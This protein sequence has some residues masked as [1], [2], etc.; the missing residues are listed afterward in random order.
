MPNTAR[1]SWDVEIRERPHRVSALGGLAAP[2]REVVPERAAV[3]FADASTADLVAAAARLSRASVLYANLMHQV[4]VLETRGRGEEE[5]LAA[6]SRVATS[7]L[8]RTEVSTGTEAV[9]TPVEVRGRQCGCLVLFPTGEV[10][11]TQV[12]ML[13]RAAAAV[14]MRLRIEDDHQVA[15]EARQSLLTRLVSGR[16]DSAGVMHARAAALGC[17]TR[18]RHFLPVVAELATGDLGPWFQRAVLEVHPDSLVGQPASGR[19][20][21]LLMLGPDRAAIRSGRT[22]AT[23]IAL[24]LLEFAARHGLGRP[25][26]ARG[27][28]VADLGEVR[29]AWTEAVEVGV[30]SSAVTGARRKP[31]YTIDDV[32]ERM[33]G[34]LLLKGGPEGDVQ[35]TTLAV[36][37]RWQGNKST[38]AQELGI[39]RPTLYDR[40]AR[41]QRPLRVDRNDPEVR[42]SLFAAMTIADVGT[43]EGTPVCCQPPGRSRAGRGRDDTGQAG[44]PPL[45]QLTPDSPAPICRSSGEPVRADCRKPRDK[46]GQERA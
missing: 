22:H 44:E 23:R 1:T 13:E 12:V 20:G 4:L 15:A 17:P 28:V 18:D 33:L 45:R 46:T 26:V 6:W 41:L 42:M 24:R 11:A 21:A 30:A 35:L 38:A 8:Y 31:L 32:A 36:Y 10:D 9:M 40:L 5:V 7:R 14:A 3:T 43:A 27:P 39:S 16:F 19:W 25:T 34:P 2:A 29:L 37:L